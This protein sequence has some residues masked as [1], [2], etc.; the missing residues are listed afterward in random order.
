[1]HIYKR[2]L[3]Q[4]MA[5]P[6]LFGFFAFSSLVVGPQLLKMATKIQNGF[7]VDIAMKIVLWSLPQIIVL[8]LPMSM[9]LATMLSLG[10]LSGHSE[11]IAM[12][13][14]GV[15]VISLAKPF[16]YMGLLT[17]LLGV[18]I[19]ETI[20][21]FAETKVKELEVIAVS[22]KNALTQRDFISMDYD[23]EG[24]VRSVIHAQKAEGKVFSKATV[25]NK[26]NG[27]LVSTI[28]AEKIYY[29]ENEGWFAE[30]GIVV[31]YNDNNDRPFYK[32]SFTSGAGATH[33]S[34]RHK[35]EELVTNRIESEKYNFFKLRKILLG[36][37]KFPQARQLWLEL[38]NK[39]SIPFAAV[40]FAVVGVPLGIRSNRRSSSVGF[41]FCVVIIMIYYLMMLVGN[42]LGT[43]ILPPFLASWWQNIVLG[44]YGVYKLVKLN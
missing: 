12:R 3:Y 7:A 31:Y 38:H 25:V 43:T 20:V 32:I 40:I 6:F 41:G 44:G 27:K 21:P 24:N 22:G 5:G 23:A 16:I 19:Q 2:Y 8:V 34:I 42:I 26:E 11:V 30:N 4:E 33:L 15:S 14:G 1:M 9:L 17:S 29:D 35:P 28:E 36:A 13:A 10:R 39:I 37:G 18:V